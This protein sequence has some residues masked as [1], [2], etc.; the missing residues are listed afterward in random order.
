MIDRA[1]NA[2]TFLKYR[3]VNY[4]QIGGPVEVSPETLRMA[5]LGSLR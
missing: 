3:D 1:G 4:V 5:L 2:G